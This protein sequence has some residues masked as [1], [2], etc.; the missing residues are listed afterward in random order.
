VVF[1]EEQDINEKPIKLDGGAFEI[2]TERRK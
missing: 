2:N 1:L